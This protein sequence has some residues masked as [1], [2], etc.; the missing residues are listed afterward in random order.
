MTTDPRSPAAFA[1]G[2]LAQSGQPTTVIIA[3]VNKAGTTSLFEYL[4][5][6]PDISPARIKELRYFTRL[7]RD[8]AVPD[9]G[10]YDDLFNYR[11]NSRYRLEAS[12]AYLCGG[13]RVAELV[14]SCLPDARII[15]LLREPVERL[16]SLYNRAVAHSELPAH[17]SF[18]DFVDASLKWRP[19]E[20]ANY[21][22]TRGLR[23]GFY[24][25]YLRE[26]HA[27]FG[28]NLEILF[29][30]DLKSDSRALTAGVCR[31]LGIDASLLASEPFEISNR[32][33]H[34]RFRGIHS[35]ITRWYMKTEAYWRRH[36]G[37][38]RAIRRMY[39]RINGARAELPSIGPETLEFLHRVYAPY[40]AELREFLIERRIP[41]P[42]W[43][44]VS[45][46]RPLRHRESVT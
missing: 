12:P 5:A 22:Y 16:L 36:P 15:V 30:D 1:S 19:G 21:A 40:N 35:Y 18:R 4:A 20:T 23:D 10:E 8:G 14:K 11:E 34:Y 27:L 43:L 17:L 25:D 3:G 44:K 6:H 28:E 9:P 26:W 42:R 33:L 41:L 39:N 29:T 2:V 32:T 13:R 24:I 37:V 46:D 31:W 38:K 7:A 45:E